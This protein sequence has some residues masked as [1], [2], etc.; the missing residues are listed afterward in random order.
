MQ[1]N[2]PIAVWV[3]QN[4]EAYDDFG[5]IL[6]TGFMTIPAS[7]NFKNKTDKEHSM[8]GIMVC[9][10]WAHVCKRRAPTSQ[11]I[12]PEFLDLSDFRVRVHVTHKTDGSFTVVLPKR[13][14]TATNEEIDAWIQE[15]FN[16]ITDWI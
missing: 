3:K 10:W 5:L 9:T 6:P 2:Q 8:A 16:G 15:N 7:M 4:N 11:L 12:M 14:H 13:L 1:T